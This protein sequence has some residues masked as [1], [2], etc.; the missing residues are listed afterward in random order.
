[1]QRYNS[2]ISYMHAISVVDLAHK[3]SF[4]NILSAHLEDVFANEW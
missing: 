3:V 4:D 1:M 2:D